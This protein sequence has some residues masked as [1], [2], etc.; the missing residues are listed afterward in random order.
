MYVEKEDDVIQIIGEYGIVRTIEQMFSDNGK[1]I[2]NKTVWYDV[3]LENGDG[4]IVFS[5]QTL[6]DARKWAKENEYGYKN[7]I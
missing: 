2:G 1:K 4:D 3:C 5:C 6:K 7:W